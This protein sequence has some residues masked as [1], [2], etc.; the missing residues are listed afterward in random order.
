MPNAIQAAEA[1]RR[2]SAYKLRAELGDGRSVQG[3]RLNIS[4]AQRSKRMLVRD[5]DLR[6][7]GQG[8]R[9]HGNGGRFTPTSAAGTASPVAG[10]SL[11]SFAP[12]VFEAMVCESVCQSRVLPTD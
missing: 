3:Y 1:S 2:A 11:R 8:T 12:L 7:R 10:L 9:F 5:H 6:S 4:V